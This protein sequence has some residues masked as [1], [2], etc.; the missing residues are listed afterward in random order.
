MHLT[1]IIKPYLVA[2]LLLAVFVAGCV[3]APVQEMSDARQA[4]Q[5]AEE[6]GA[7]RDAQDS[8]TRAVELMRAAEDALNRGDYALA[9]ERAL[10]AK[11]AALTARTEAVNHTSN[12]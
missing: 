7:P 10:A 2:V 9:R 11:A 4:L 5:A 3:G 12:P 8:Y 6:V 1:K